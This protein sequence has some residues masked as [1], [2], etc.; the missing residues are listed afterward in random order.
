MAGGG[1]LLALR[2]GAAL[3]LKARGASRVGLLALAL[4]SL[5]GVRA[6]SAASLFLAAQNLQPALRSP[7]LIQE[8]TAP[9]GVGVPWRHRDHGQARSLNSMKKHSHVGS[10]RSASPSRSGRG[11]QLAEFHLKGDVCASP[12]EGR[13]SLRSARPRLGRDTQKD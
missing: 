3:R 2:L 6:L 11:T 4:T 5:A 7:A 1:A 12:S 9:L 10:C 8:T 13:E